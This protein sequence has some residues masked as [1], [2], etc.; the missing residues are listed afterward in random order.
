MSVV[1]YLLIA[2]IV[3]LWIGPYLFGRFVR[4]RSPLNLRS[5]L[6]EEGIRV[7]L[8]R[9]YEGLRFLGPPS[10][11]TSTPYLF[12][13]EYNLY[14]RV[15]GTYERSYDSIREAQAPGMM[16]LHLLFKDNA[17]YVTFCLYSRSDLQEVL[18]F[19][20]GKGV[21]LGARARLLLQKRIESDAAS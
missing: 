16:Q 1:E 6:P 10:E 17:R 13:S 18:R 9:A 8:S 2:V 5:P 19:L 14:Y 7:P 3:L 12:L 15:L 4:Q 21:P 11:S 20:Y